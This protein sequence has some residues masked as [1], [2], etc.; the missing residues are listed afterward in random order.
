MHRFEPTG[1]DLD[2]FWQVSSS[3]DWCERNYVVSWYIAE[4]WN[5]ISSLIIVLCGVI[6]L[7]FA[8]NMKAEL[9]FKLYAFSVILVGWGTIAFHASL[10]YVGQI[11][12][13][14][15]MVWCMMI[16]WYILL[17]MEKKQNYSGNTLAKVLAIYCFVF[18]LVHTIG[19]FT[20]LFQIHF[21]VLM[22][23]PLVY[24]YKLVEKYQ[25]HPQ[26]KSLGVFYASLWAVAGV[27]WLLDQLYCENLHSLRLDF[28]GVEIPNPQ[29]HA[30]W[31]LLTGFCTHV[32]MVKMYVIR[33]MVLYNQQLSII[34]LY[35]F[36]PTISSSPS[37]WQPTK[38]RKSH[39]PEQPLNVIKR[40]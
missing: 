22:L 35:G 32:G 29:L 17:T 18:S 16:S 40:S 30:F 27:V 2:G 21:V 20:V 23:V 11:G 4:F 26:L 31:H 6:D 34:W 38:A 33:Q 36:W 3:I 13:E 12:D 24:G 19:A 5:S 14:L 1:N 15:P 25:A 28:I 9:R 8:I 7:M 37:K 10:T 39:V